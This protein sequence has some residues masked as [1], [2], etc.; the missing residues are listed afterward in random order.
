VTFI[1]AVDV[2]GFERLLLETVKLAF[3]VKALAPAYV[4]VCGPIPVA[5]AGLAPVPKFHE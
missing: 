3:V 1:T 4:T 5:V 2:D